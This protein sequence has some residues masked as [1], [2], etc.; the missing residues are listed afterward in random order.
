MQPSA[1]R[2]AAGL[3]GFLLAAGAVEARKQSRSQGQYSLQMTYDR[4]NFFQSFDFFTGPDPTHGFVE[5]V[6]QA[7]AQQDGLIGNAAR[8]NSSSRGYGGPA[9]NGSIILGVDYKTVNPT[10]GRRSVRVTSQQSFTQGLFLADIFHTPQAACGVW[11][12]FW[13]FDPNWPTSG[14]IDIIEGVN[15]QQKA[16][17]TL[18][19]GPGCRMSNEGALS[20]TYLKSDQCGGGGSKGGCGQQTA[21]SQNYG[22]GFN[23]VRGGVY[24]TE[25]TSEHIAMWFFPRGGIPRDVASGQPDPASWGQPMA[26]FAGGDG[27]DID[28]HFSEN[29]L[30]F[31]TTFCGDWAGKPEVWSSNKTCAAK[32]S[33][34]DDYVAANPSAFRNAYWEINSIKVFQQDGSGGRRPTQTY[35]L[36]KATQTQQT[37]TQLGG[38][39]SGLLPPRP[40]QPQR[41]RA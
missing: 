22:D 6:D 8:G 38:E 31:D 24:V 25:W 20:S 11:P 39:G 30:V 40:F 27:C 36:P 37:S 33:T 21:D 12:A 7:T 3:G 19:T 29:Q 5:Y 35:R 41:W 17:V 9:N 15:M 28:S 13:M 1:Y 10:K 4:S 16:T 26:R 2:L 34:C 23:A 32:A 14:E 18:Q